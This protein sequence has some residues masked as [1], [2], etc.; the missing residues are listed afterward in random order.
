MPK[1]SGLCDPQ[2]ALTED[3]FKTLKKIAPNTIAGSRHREK[4]MHH[5]V[6]L[7]AVGNTT[8]L[9][10]E[11]GNSGHWRLSGGAVSLP[12][13]FDAFDKEFTVSEIML[14]YSNAP[15]V[16]RKKQHA[17]GSPECR[18]A[19]YQRLKTYGHYGHRDQ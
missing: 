6:D 10:S 1:D 11:P 16:L 14:W 4:R 9:R 15:K 2:F 7:V 19:A 18:A 17:W 12:M 3:N 13:L 8:I 5:S